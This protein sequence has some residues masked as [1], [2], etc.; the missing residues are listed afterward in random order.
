MDRPEDGGISRFLDW[1]CRSVANAFL[2]C[3][4]PKKPGDHAEKIK[5][6]H[7]T[8]PIPT[9]GGRNPAVLGIDEIL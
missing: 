8:I 3:G 7:A 4:N 6:L 1:D 2:A 9:V 5:H